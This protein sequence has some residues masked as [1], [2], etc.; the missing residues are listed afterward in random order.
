MYFIF[1]KKAKIISA[2]DEKIIAELEYENAVYTVLIQKNEE[3]P[4]PAS[5]YRA[6]AYH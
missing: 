6:A 1:I 3:R 4:I 2:K 5:Q